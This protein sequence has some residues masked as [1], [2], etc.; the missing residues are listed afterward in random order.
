MK[1]GRSNTV[2]LGFLSVE[3][4]D[5]TKLD[6]TGNVLAMYHF[7]RLIIHDVAVTQDQ[8]R[9]VCVGTLTAS[10]DGLHPSKCRAEKQ[11]IGRSQRRYV[12]M[13][14]TE[15]ENVVYNMETE[16]I[17]KY[18]DS[19]LIGSVRTNLNGSRVPVLHEVRDITLA[20]NDQVALVSYENK[21]SSAVSSP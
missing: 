17:E 7:E 11:I 3:G 9:M 14:V 13:A 12:A 5:V 18:A 2:T 8:A 4:S 6:L 21:V 15:Q 16:K 19:M 10:M 1:L 20:R